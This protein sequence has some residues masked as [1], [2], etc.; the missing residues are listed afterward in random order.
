MLS[1]EDSIMDVSELTNKDQAATEK[2]DEPQLPVQVTFQTI[3][4]MEKK[5]SLRRIA[6]R[7]ASDLQIGLDH[8]P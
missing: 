4:S 5:G 3:T 6:S 7:E 1:S 8:S 2:S